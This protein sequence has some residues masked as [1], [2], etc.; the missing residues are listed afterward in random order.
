MGSEVYDSLIKNRFRVRVLTP[1]S[2]GIA[3]SFPVCDPRRAAHM[4]HSPRPLRPPAPREHN[5]K[6][7]AEIIT[8]SLL[9]AISIMVME[10]PLIHFIQDN[11]LMRIGCGSL[12]MCTA[13]AV[14]ALLRPNTTQQTHTS[15]T[16]PTNV[17]DRNPKQWSNWSGRVSPSPSVRMCC[18]P[19]G[20]SE[21]VRS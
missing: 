16:F 1:S 11:G 14:R 10:K 18:P 19:V 13:L 3:V 2:P 6:S 7:S 12:T 9:T 15:D 21:E 4:S 17:Y 5:H 20:G 8:S